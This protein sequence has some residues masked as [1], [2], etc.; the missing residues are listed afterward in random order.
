MANVKNKSENSD[1]SSKIKAKK[2]KVRLG[3]GKFYIRS[4]FNNTIIT[5]T[6]AEGNTISWASGGTMDF[7]GSRKST[8]YAAQLAARKVADQIKELGVHEVEIFVRGPGVGRE[9]AIRSVIA[10]G[11]KVQFIK[12]VTP[13]PHNGC[14][15]CKKR[16]V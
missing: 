2:E 16:R 11:I 9:S 1:K 13:L 5:A 6:D 12:D 4:N 8:P 14:R 15:P 10:S 7:K 3:R